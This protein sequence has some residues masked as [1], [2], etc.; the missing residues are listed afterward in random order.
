V[1]VLAE[2]DAPAHEMAVRASPLPLR[3]GG[4]SAATSVNPGSQGQ[5]SRSDAHGFSYSLAPATKG[6]RLQVVFFV[7]ELSHPW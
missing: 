3:L 1:E 4:A 6:S 5:L 7:L 2:V